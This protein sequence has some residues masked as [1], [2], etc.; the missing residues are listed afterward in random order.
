MDNTKIVQPVIVKPEIK[1]KR[2]YVKKVSQLPVVQQNNPTGIEDMLKLAITNKVDVG[3]LERL[4]AMRKE[5][6]AEKAKEDFD[7]SM[8]A[9]QA[10]CPVIQKDKNVLGKDKI[11]VR[12]K[13]APLESI[14]YQIKDLITKHG[15][16]Y[17]FETN[18]QEKLIEVICIVNH[19][20]GHSEKSKFSVPVGIEDYMTEVQKYGAR[21]TF[22]KRYT[23]KNAFGLTETG[24]DIDGNVKDK[25]VDELELDNKSITKINT[26]RNIQELNVICKALQETLGPKYRKSLVEEY[27]LKKEELNKK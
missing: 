18:N 24:E 1:L 12:Y 26:A 3:T 11:T 17:K 22:A 5:I 9:F 4:M 25:K 7:K 16:S 8:A 13:Y 20:S 6:K 19:K 15:F 10:E 21:V 27:G 2:K 23:L 14:I